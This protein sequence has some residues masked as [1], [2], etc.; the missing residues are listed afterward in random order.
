MYN[1]VT[2]VLNTVCVCV[3]VCNALRV[4]ILCSSISLG[5]HVFELLCQLLR[6]MLK[7]I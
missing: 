7:Y 1:Y 5:C 3:C 2:F 6:I 4:I